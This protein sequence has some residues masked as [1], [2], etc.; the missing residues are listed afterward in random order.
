M[1][2][3]GQKHFLV[4][5]FIFHNSSRNEGK[6]DGRRNKKVYFKIYKKEAFFKKCVLQLKDHYVF[7][8]SSI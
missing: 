1:V 6:T 7:H 4:F 2:L 3:S 5:M 8:F